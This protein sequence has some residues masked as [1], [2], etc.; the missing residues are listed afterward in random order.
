MGAVRLL[1]IPKDFFTQGF[2]F[3]MWTGTA[4]IAPDNMT[5]AEALKVLIGKNIFNSPEFWEGFES[6]YKAGQL[7]NADLE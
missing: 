3:D 7:T 6:K 5:L 1:R 4:K 2:V